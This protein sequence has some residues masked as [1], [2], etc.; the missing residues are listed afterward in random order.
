MM[1]RIRD[2]VMITTTGI[3]ALLMGAAT[4]YW[5]YQFNFLHYDTAHLKLWL[6]SMVSFVG[7]AVATFAIYSRIQLRNERQA[8]EQKT[9]ALLKGLDNCLAKTPSDERNKVAQLK[10]AQV[11]RELN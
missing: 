3:L 1:T 10:V 4:V 7:F 5:I 8:L 9:T 2:L 6:S 11:I